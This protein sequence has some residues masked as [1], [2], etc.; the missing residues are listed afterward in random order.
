MK[1]R[2]IRLLVAA[3]AVSAAVL[4][5]AATGSAHGNRGDRNH[6]R[7]PDRWE[8]AF[9]LSLKVNQAQRDQ[10]HDGMRNRAEFMA[11]TNPR[12]ADS[13]DDGTKDDDE[14][15]GTV[16]SFENGVLVVHL[17]NGDDVKGT[18]DDQT[19]IRCES[20]AMGPIVV[21]G[22]RKADEGPGGDDHGDHH[23]DDR[24][25]DDNEDQCDAGALTAGAVVHEAE[26]KTTAGGLVF[27]E[28]EI[29][30]ASS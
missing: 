22:A 12:R 20:R 3:A 6:D 8:R 21:S 17:F 4:A 13:D 14:G 5:V 25:D 15:A 1:R 10:D 24:G 9:H 27:R 30:V 2:T 19:E 26:L 29:V 18:V 23:G 11:G 7:I 28:I 16:T